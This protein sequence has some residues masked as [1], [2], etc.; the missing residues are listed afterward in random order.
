MIDYDPNA[1]VDQG[2]QE[3]GQVGGT[4]EQFDVQPRIRK[5]L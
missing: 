3:G 1:A 2:R 4:G 5:P